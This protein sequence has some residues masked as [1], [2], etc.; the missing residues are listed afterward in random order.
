M[1]PLAG[2]LGAPGLC[3]GAPYA[4][5]RPRGYDPRPMKRRGNVTNRKGT[6]GYENWMRK[7]AEHRARSSAQ[8]RALGVLKEELERLLRERPSDEP[9]ELLQYLSVFAD[10]LARFLDDAPEADAAEILEY[11]CAL[12]GVAAPPAP[13]RRAT[14][15]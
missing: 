12:A 7:T 1:A 10:E 14:K 15:R 3:R 8:A 11:L 13:R 2:A 5:Q 6:P 9:G 4:L